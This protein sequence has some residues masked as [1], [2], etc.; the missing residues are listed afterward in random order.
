M[1]CFVYRGGRV[2]ALLDR[3]LKVHQLLRLQQSCSTFIGMLPIYSTHT[4]DYRRGV[5]EIQEVSVKD[6]DEVRRLKLPL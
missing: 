4:R 2:Y 5:Q 6:M 1:A 3:F